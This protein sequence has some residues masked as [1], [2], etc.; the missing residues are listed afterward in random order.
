MH[1]T[2]R[3]R[4]LAEYR[5]AL[6]LVAGYFKGDA[7]KAIIWMRTANPMLGGLVPREMI[8]KGLYKKL[9]QFIETSLEENKPPVSWR[10]EAPLAGPATDGLL[11]ALNV[12]QLELPL[13]C[14]HSEGDT[15]CGLP[16]C[17][18]EWPR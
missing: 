6:K 17:G 15:Q 16:E 12:E 7:M 18:G 11:T 3:D 2:I 1:N 8:V 13:T 14:T 4:R 9:L 5:Q 10:T